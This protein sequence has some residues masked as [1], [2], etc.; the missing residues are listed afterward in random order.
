MSQVEAMVSDFVGTVEDRGPYFGGPDEVEPAHL[1][2]GKAATGVRWSDR[3]ATIADSIAAA[4]PNEAQS[5]VLAEL[6]LRRHRVAGIVWRAAA[7]G[8]ELW[9]VATDDLGPATIPVRLL[10][11]PEVREILDRRLRSIER[12]RYEAS[13][14]VEPDGIGPTA[15]KRRWMLRQDWHFGSGSL[16]RALRNSWSDDFSSRK[17]EAP[18]VPVA[19]FEALFVDTIVDIPENERFFSWN[20]ELYED[21]LSETAYKTTWYR[22]RQTNQFDWNLWPGTVPLPPRWRYD[23]GVKVIRDA[24]DQDWTL[25]DPATPDARR[26][27]GWLMQPFDNMSQR[28]A[29]IVDILFIPGTHD[30]WNRRWLHADGV[31]SAIHLDALLNARRR[32]GVPDDEFNQLASRWEMALDD[33][34]GVRGYRALANGIMGPGR[35]EFFENSAVPLYDLQIGDQVLMETNLIVFA[36]ASWW[37]YPTLLVTD[38]DNEPDSEVI[39]LSGIRLQGFGTADFSYPS[40]QF[41]LAKVVDETLQVV[42]AR[43]VEKVEAR[44]REIDAGTSPFDL[45]PL[46]SIVWDTGRAGSRD[47]QFEFDMRILY[48]WSPY[49]DEWDHPGAWWLRINLREPMWHGVFG[50]DVEAAVRNLHKSVAWIDDANVILEDRMRVETIPVRPGFV[51]PPG[52]SVDDD[53]HRVIFIPLFEPTI[54]IMG[55]EPWLVYFSV[56]RDGGADESFPTELRPVRTDAAWLPQLAVNNQAIRV[57]RPRQH[58]G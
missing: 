1:E 48:R 46:Q 31:I 52:A 11:Q 20:V 9:D 5:R 38:V 21:P 18:S 28:P 36:I 15:I 12:M 32:R 58:R 27:Y 25:S 37:D 19:E 10:R 35:T 47:Q 51:P 41:E 50:T 4:T 7:M 3:S 13:S 29:D 23:Q 56:K 55:Y 14:G 54:D 49:G 42:Q 8:D 17:F 30:W 16:K 2:I 22:N 6:D 44:Q 34:F 26:G 43:I 24:E 40:L 33:Y 53:P 57:I 45:G 39:S